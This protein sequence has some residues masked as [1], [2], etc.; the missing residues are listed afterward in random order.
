MINVVKVKKFDQNEED[1]MNSIIMNKD[2]KLNDQ[3][4]MYSKKTQKYKSR[5]VF[6]GSLLL[7]ESM[8]TGRKHPQ[9]FGQNAHNMDNV[10]ITTIAESDAET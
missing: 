10:E 4:S 2:L 3:A 8:M 1:F 9:G 5:S 7:Q 6:K